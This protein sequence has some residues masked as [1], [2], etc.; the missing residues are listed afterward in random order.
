MDNGKG[1]IAGLFLSLSLA[2]CGPSIFLMKDWKSYESMQSPD[3]ISFLADAIA[4]GTD[5]DC[6]KAVKEIRKSYF[7]LGPD[8]SRVVVPLREAKLR[9]RIRNPKVASDISETLDTLELAGIKATSYAEGRTAANNPGTAGSFDDSWEKLVVA[10]SAANKHQDAT[11][12][13]A[14]SQ[15]TIAVLDFR[16]GGG[17]SSSDAAVAADWLRSTLVNSHRFQVIERQN[18]D[19]ILAEQAFQQTGCTE[20]GCAVKLGKIL[21]ASLIITGNFSKFMSIYVVSIHVVKVETGEIVHADEGR[22]KNED[23][24]IAA[25]RKM[26]DKMTLALS[27]GN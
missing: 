22:G 1:L 8:V 14:S 17:L 16:P 7:V 27:S 26:G 10:D 2:C 18:M 19:K 23:D 4:S 11:A 6:W 21:N 5:S 13:S 24:L 25:I 12:T 20:Q 15:L 3:R 9:W